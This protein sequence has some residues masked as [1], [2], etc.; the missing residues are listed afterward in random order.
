MSIQSFRKQLIKEGL[1]QKTTLNEMDVYDL[2][3]LVSLPLAYY[4]AK[5]IFT[6]F[7]YAAGRALGKNFVPSDASVKA[8][9][10]LWKDSGFIKDFATIIKN[11]GDFN[12]FIKRTQTK[13]WNGEENWQTIQWGGFQK[14]KNSAAD[15]VKKAMRTSSFQRI[16]KKYKLDKDDTQFVGNT[17]FFTITSESFRKKA[18]DIRNSVFSDMAEDEWGNK[19]SK[20]H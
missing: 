15:V 10:E 4:A 2:A 11:E 20:K 14:Y 16:I 17:L 18:L 12:E 8:A 6:G 7:M 19:K 3:F 13:N 5:Y 1:I 9:G